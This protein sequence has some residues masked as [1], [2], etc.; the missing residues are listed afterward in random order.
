MFTRSSDPA[1]MFAQHILAVDLGT[2][3]CKTALV[4][5]EGKVAGWAFTAVP[6]HILPGNGVEQ[7][8]VDW[9]SAFVSST[10]MV[11]AK[12]GIP[13]SAVAAICCSCAGEATVA[14]DRE[15]RPLR[16]AILYADARG[17]P[18]IRRQVRGL[19]NAFGYDALKLVRW[20]RLTGGAPSLTGK[21]PA[22]HM[23]LVR[24][25][26]PDVYAAT[27][28]FLNVLDYMNLRLTGRF[29]ATH[30]SILTSWVTDNRH[31]DRIRYDS[32]LL[33]ASGID[34]DKFPELVAC[35]E[36]LGGLLPQA[37]SDLGLPRS[38]PVVAGAVDTSAAA[39]GSGAVAD[40]EPHLY[41]GTSSWIGAHVPFKKTDLL[42]QVAS[43]PCAVPA[44]YLMI[45]MQS[46]AG[47]A[48]AFLRDRLLF[49]EAPA[50]KAEIRA[51]CQEE[52]SPAA[53][54]PKG[55]K[56][57]DQMA[58][59][60]PVGSRG[61]LFAPWFTG[62]RSP[63]ADPHL[64]AGLWNLSL[65]HSR[66]DVVRAVLEGVALNTR[67]MLKPV[68]RFLGR[69]LEELPIAGGGGVSD[70]WC[71][72]FADVLGLRIRQLQEPMQSNALGAAYIAAVGVG[73]MT[74]DKV[75]SLTRWKAVYEPQA[76]HR[77]VYDRM[78]EAFLEV[79][80]RMRPMYR[81]LNET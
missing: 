2:S 69:R 13:P 73:L 6:L 38:T 34:S 15:G 16:N 19:V 17:M 56:L 39:I 31:P 76:A 5:L 67:W 8:P 12:T 61:L 50:S 1:I 75:P 59:R 70:L 9:W 74:F 18:H 11:L 35:T 77:E 47:G 52:G 60:V 29:V 30:D 33:A 72:I 51:S 25:D 81:K 68:E 49:D 80:R 42:T 62:E 22:A 24:D 71:Q 41:I 14:V 79:H 58:S 3:G 78:F 23:L 40:L 26:F 10:R 63:V 57:L 65:E 66:Q 36:V 45:A 54:A 28:K 32:G 37:A 21:D 27:Y 53:S 4:T 44:R 7:D 46:L 43:V 64:R 48:L 55:Y 20:I